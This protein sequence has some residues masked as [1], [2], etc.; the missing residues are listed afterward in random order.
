MSISKKISYDEYIIA[1]FG[2]FGIFAG[3][4]ILVFLISCVL[5]I[6][7]SRMGLIEEPLIINNGLDLEETPDEIQVVDESRIVQAENNDETRSDDSS[8]DETDIDFLD[9]ADKDKDIFR[10]KFSSMNLFP[11]L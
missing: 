8:L 9:D 6:K 10:Y 5:C 7:D 4:Y 3:L 2:A 11:A 1:T